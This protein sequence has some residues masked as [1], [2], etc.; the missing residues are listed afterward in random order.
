L[1]FLDSYKKSEGEYIFRVQGANF[2]VPPR[3]SSLSAF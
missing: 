1:S 2:F 3:I